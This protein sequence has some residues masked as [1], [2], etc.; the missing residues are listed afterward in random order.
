M[1]QKVNLPLPQDALPGRA[2]QFPTAS[3]HFVTGRPL[4]GALP[5]GLEVAYFGMG[6][7]WGVERLFWQIPGVWLTAAGY[8]GGI[9]PNPTYPETC[10]GLTGH[11]ET[12]MVVFDPEVI[13]YRDLL[14]VFWESHDPT[15]GMRQGNDIGTTYRSAIYTTSDL[16]TAEAESSRDAYEKALQSA[17]RGGIT[18][19]IAPAGEFY[20]AEA[21]HQQY[22][23]KNPNGYCGLKG[24]GVS[25]AIP[26]AG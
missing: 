13:S 9:T 24:T 8:Q 4:R 3:T 12:V 6:C 1:S 18:T 20:F 22:L 25:C 23:A 26:V 5:E 16:Q 7:F 19:E 21:E 10:T 17:G 11:A 2:T 14:K 15:Q